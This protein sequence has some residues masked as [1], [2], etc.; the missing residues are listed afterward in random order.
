M[1]DVII[2]GGTTE[3][4]E[5]A[6]WLAKR[7]IEVLVSVATE[8]GK[9][10]LEP[11]EKLTVRT[12]RLDLDGMKYLIRQQHPKLVLDATHPHAQE[13]TRIVRLVCEMLHVRCERVVRGEEQ[14][15]AGHVIWVDTPQQAAQLLLEDKRAV[16]LTT[17][18]KELEIFTSVPELHH[19]IYARVL[20]DSKV[21]ASCEALGIRGR[22]LIAMQGPFSTEMNCA[23]IKAVDAGWLVTKESGSSGGFEE[24]IEAAK[25]CGAKAIVIRRPQEETA[26]LTV[27]AVK[28]MLEEMF[29]I[30]SEKDKRILSLIGM[31]MGTGT[32]L[33][34]EALQAIRESDAVLGAPRMLQ[35][36]QS[37]IYG[38]KTAPVYLGKDILVWMQENQQYRRIAVIYSG[39]TGFHSGAASLIREIEQRA[40]EIQN[41]WEIQTNV[42]P[43][44]STVSCLC[45]R[46]HLS[47]ENLYMASAHGKKCDPAEILKKHQRVFLLL[48]GTSTVQG[49]CRRL[50]EAGLGKT[51]VFA[52]VRLG[53][54]DE[55]LL[56]GTAQSLQ[57]AEADG[58]AAVILDL[59][60]G[61]QCCRTDR[62]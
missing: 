52:G 6:Q 16:L 12:G 11:E 14:A 60:N 39:D 37:L 62:D 28:Q 33:T 8:Y 30:P 40:K 22:Q 31:G 23:L 50:T 45:A 57:S 20:P 24:K 36:I 15:D 35:D 32:Q 42:Y 51:S 49:I 53:Y 5:M 47:W 43:G 2:F 26:G 7:G 9:Q 56:C 10:V 27:R 48:G 55:K 21:L 18:S 3:G 44:I 19:R 41:V 46:F 1:T 38:K 58:L 4:R 17:G 25:H 59:N 54:E 34:Q 61:E 13:V 29:D